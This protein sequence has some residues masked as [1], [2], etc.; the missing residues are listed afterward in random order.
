MKIEIIS[1]IIIILTNQSKSCEHPSP[2][3]NGK[4]FS[5]KSK[6]SNRYIGKKAGTRNI[7]QKHKTAQQGDFWKFQKKHSNIYFI[8]NT[9]TH[10]VMDIEGGKFQKKHL[11]IYFFIKKKVMDIKGGKFQK[12]NIKIYILS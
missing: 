3:L 7:T 5:I 8:I 1:L 11:N 4:I 2:D 6:K 9:K 12:K 10:K